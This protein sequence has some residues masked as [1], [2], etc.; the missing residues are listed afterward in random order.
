MWIPR[1]PGRSR[2]SPTVPE[3]Q[4]ME[5]AGLRWELGIAVLLVPIWCVPPWE[6]LT[7]LS[8]VGRFFLGFYHFLACCSCLSRGTAVTPA[9]A[10]GEFLIQP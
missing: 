7:L 9:R 10:V 6:L 5:P 8:P 1:E 3:P 2:I 4:G